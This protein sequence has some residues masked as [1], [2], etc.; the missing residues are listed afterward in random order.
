MRCHYWDPLT[1]A[2]RSEGLATLPTSAPGSSSDRLHCRVNDVTATEFAGICVEGWM[3]PIL[4]ESAPS[5]DIAV[6][7]LTP[8]ARRVVI[9]LSSCFGLYLLSLLHA[10]RLLRRRIKSGVEAAKLKTHSVLPE[11]PVPQKEVVP[12]KQSP[13]A[14]KTDEAE[15]EPCALPDSPAG[16]GIPLPTID[17]PTA[18]ESVAQGAEV[19][20][21]AADAVLQELLD[22]PDLLLGKED[23]AD[24]TKPLYSHGRI[25]ILSAGLVDSRIGAAKPAG[26]M[27]PARSADKMV[28][29]RIPMDAS[30]R[31]LATKRLPASSKGG[32]ISGRLTF[33]G[34][35][36]P[37]SFKPPGLQEQGAGLP[38]AG[39]QLLTGRLPMQT[40]NLPLQ[41]GRLQLQ[42][43]RLPMQTGR[44]PMQTGRLP[45]RAG[46]VPGSLD[47]QLG[48]RS[49]ELPAMDALFRGNQGGLLRTTSMPQQRLFSDRIPMDLSS[50]HS[51]IPLEPGAQRS[52]STSPTKPVQPGSPGSDGPSPGRSLGLEGI[53]LAD[54][55]LADDLLSDA[56]I[57]AQDSAPRTLVHSRIPMDLRPPARFDMLSQSTSSARAPRATAPLPP[58]PSPQAGGSLPVAQPPSPP[59]SPPSSSEPP[60]KATIGVE[61]LSGKTSSIATLAELGSSPLMSFWFFCRTEHTLSGAVF[62]PQRRALDPP[63]RVQVLWNVI[64]LELA[65]ITMVASSRTSATQ[66]V[67]WAHV[68]LDAV[69]ISVAGAVIGAVSKLV[70]RCAG[71]RRWQTSLTWLANLAACAAGSFLFAWYLVDFVDTKSDRVFAGWGIS[72]AFTWCVIEPFWVL[73]VVTLVHAIILPATELLNHGSAPM[74]SRFSQNKYSVDEPGEPDKTDKTDV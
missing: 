68:V 45:L 7:V 49:T 37:P 24:P 40:G 18:A 67:G 66:P 65:G 62:P 56:A 36:R 50:I 69:F 53:S 5:V 47:G 29:G 58:Q 63:Q 43:G 34:L 16:T 1:S 42:T 51:R 46:I 48:S 2:W 33:S 72:L 57:A 70:F 30:L 35:E 12:F 52:P 25:P 14:K 39:G 61:Q 11:A 10:R 71:T 23:E 31:T 26:L 17:L 32:I 74:P 41:T 44:L 60:Q 28:S 4:P 64:M 19:A 13:P 59:P 20:S 8:G 27:P 22:G 55:A 3:D 15:A 6:P 38:A 54:L 73:T 9:T 21:T